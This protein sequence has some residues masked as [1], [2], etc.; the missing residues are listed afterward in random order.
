MLPNTLHNT[1]D[2]APHV[3]R[4]IANS[5]PGESVNRVI[6]F[7]SLRLNTDLVDDPIVWIKLWFYLIHYIPAPIPPIPAGP[8]LANTLYIHPQ[9]FHE[10][11]EWDYH[12]IDDLALPRERSII[13]VGARISALSQES[14]PTSAVF[15][16][17]TPSVP[18]V[19]MREIMLPSNLET[20]NPG[21][22]FLPTEPE[23]SVFR[24][25][26]SMSRLA[27]LDNENSE[28]DMK[29]LEEKLPGELT[30]SAQKWLSEHDDF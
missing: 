26:E 28:F 27:T 22:I 10:W 7:L 12:D 3:H 30:N 9:A 13:P 1:Q 8:E 14:R 4:V 6:R 2:F 29:C 17:E 18:T 20:S 19:S 16:Q 25:F 5:L 11:Q 21:Q 24:N 15:M 23:A